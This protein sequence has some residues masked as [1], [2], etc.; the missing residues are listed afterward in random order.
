MTC[1]LPT[2]IWTQP[3]RVGLKSAVQNVADGYINLEFEAA[4]AVAPADSFYYLIYT[5]SQANSLLAG[6]KFL[7]TAAKVS[8]PG[9]LISL[10]SYLR[11][12]TAQSGLAV[13]I[14][15]MR[16]VADNVYLFPAQTVLETDFHAGDPVAL[17]GSTEGY[18]ALDGYVSIDDQVLQ[19]SSILD[20]YDGYQGLLI[21]DPNP[22]G[23]NSLSGYQSGQTVELFRGFEESNTVQF[24]PQA[25][26]GMPLP[27]WEDGF[28]SGVRRVSDLGVGR[29][30]SVEWYD[31]RAAPGF[32]RPYFNIYQSTNL[33]DLF[34]Q[35]PVGWSRATSAVIPNLLP[36]KIYYYGVRV[37]YQLNQYSGVGFDQISSGFFKYPVPCQTDGYYL[38]ID[39]GNLFVDS[40]DG[41]PL[42][43]FLKIGSEVLRY[44]GL[45]SNAFQIR[46]RDVYTT[47]LQ[48]D[49]APAT[50]VLF[51]K[52]IEDGNRKY[53]RGVPS[54]DSGV[55]AIMP[56]PDGYNGFLA[57]GYDG[58][59][60]NQDADGYRDVPTD[61]VTEDHSVFETENSDFPEFEY[62][63]YHAQNFVKLYSGNQC[64][65]YQGGRTCA[66]IPGVNN[67]NP[68]PIAG[69]VNI[70]DIATQREELILGLTAENFILLR[71]KTTGKKCP[72]LS[73]RSEHPHARC[74]IC[75]GTT[76]LGGYDRYVNQ[77][78]LQPAVPNPNGFIAMRVS[79]YNNDLELTS[80]RGLAQ[81]D[82]L[83][84]W[85]ISIPTIKDRDIIIRYNKDAETG[86]YSEDFRYEVLN[87]N[88][89][90]L[91]L[92][93]DGKQNVSMKKLDKTRQIYSYKVPLIQ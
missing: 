16:L 64:G 20:G 35:G 24:K 69:G 75:M 84:T 87:V 28:V 12:H 86:L 36:G 38:K 25:S 11:V 72:G 15:S 55:P 23:C 10:S 29:S 32:G 60:Y 58:Q 76:F 56:L 79:P 71:R 77:R 48:R 53:F 43:G 45:T 62:C 9:S 85:T 57:D 27:T 90:K 47:G 63:G 44:D 74:G 33:I 3:N 73:I 6:P 67:G 4:R 39:S 61:I 22:F 89:N 92:G 31:G 41:F 26:S 2:P 68:V 59:A 13:D 21:S 1:Q 82:I 54:W 65:T 91:L 14:S 81:V 93:L 5:S 52:G 19:Y 18:P 66:V 51:F 42:E 80:D 7:A 70:F 40:T 34:N 37:A 78:E 17:V 83:E 88:R 50:A 30:V 46:A 8:I 49:F